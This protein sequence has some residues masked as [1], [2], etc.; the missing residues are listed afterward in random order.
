MSLEAIEEQA[1]NYLA[2]VSNPLVRIEVLLAH[3][4]DRGLA[5]SMNPNELK[6]FLSRHERVRIMEPAVSAPSMGTD[7]DEPEGAYAILTT[8]VPTPEQL[9][10]M[11]LEQL[12]TLEQ[13]LISARQAAIEDGDT[14]RVGPLDEAL[15]RV[16]AL[17]KRL[18]S[19][20]GSANQN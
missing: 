13:A 14:A 6:N 5:E 18:D 10:A 12:H 16:A 3:L 8:R 7:S 4:R 19:A 2:Q 11:M 9:A 1:L 20:S 17:H 15:R